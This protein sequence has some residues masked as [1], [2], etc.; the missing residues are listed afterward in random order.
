M[1]LTVN[2]ETRECLIDIS[3][4]KLLKNLDINEDHV[5]IELN[6]EIIPRA[7]FGE[8]RLKENDNLEIVTFVGGG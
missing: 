2:G 1:Q 3:I 6:H 4:S 8:R 5:A 7:K